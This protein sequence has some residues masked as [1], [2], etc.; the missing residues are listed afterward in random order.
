MVKQILLLFEFKL[1][2]KDNEKIQNRQGKYFLSPKY[3]SFEKLIRD[4]AFFQMRSMSFEP[5][6]K[7][8]NLQMIIRTYFKTKVHADMWNLPKSLGDALQ[9]VVYKNDKQIKSGT[10]SI[11]E[12]ADRNYF[13]VF[14]KSI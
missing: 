14:I 5:F 10:I 4:T 12:N 8:A 1:I 2:S 9:D 7:D 13:T 11:H 6:S 3:K